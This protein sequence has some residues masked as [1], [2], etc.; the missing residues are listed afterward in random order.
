IEAAYPPGRTCT[1]GASRANC[2]PGRSGLL[3]L[4]RARLRTLLAGID[5]L[6]LVTT[7]G[8]G[9]GAQRLEAGLDLQRLGGGLQF[10]ELVVQA[11]RG[12]LLLTG[13]LG[14]LAAHLILEPG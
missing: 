11:G 8:Q 7:G 6:R 3:A 5:L 4:G 12:Q 10:G 14:L 1:D 13:H 2:A 9:T